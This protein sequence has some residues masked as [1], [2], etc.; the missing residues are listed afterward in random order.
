MIKNFQRIKFLL[1]WKAAIQKKKIIFNLKT[2]GIS[3][4]NIEEGINSLKTNYVN[5]E[6]ASALIFAKKKNFLTFKKRKKNLMKL[7]KNYYKWHKLDFHI[8]LQKK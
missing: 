6:L 2:R 8:I 4:E 1:I 7:K 3:D 5:S